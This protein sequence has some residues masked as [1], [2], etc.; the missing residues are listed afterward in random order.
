MSVVY[1]SSCD[2]SGKSIK[3]ENTTSG[4]NSYLTGHNVGIGATD[5]AYVL[6]IN[7]RSR[8]RGAGSDDG[9]G[10]WLTNHD[11]PTTNLSFIGRGTDSEDFVGIYTAGGW[12]LV[13]SDSSGYVGIG[14]TSPSCELDV[15]GTA[16]ASTA[17]KT[18]AIRPVTD[19]TTAVQVQS[20]GGSSVVLNVDTTNTR[21]GIG[22]TSPSDKLDVKGNIRITA[23][24]DSYPTAQII[25]ISHDN[26]SLNFD[27]YYDNA[28]RSSDPG[29]NFRIYKHEDKLRISH[30]SGIT[31]GDTIDRWDNEGSHVAFVVDTNGNVGIGI[32][33]LVNKLTAAGCVSIGSMYGG[34][35]AP[36]DGLIVQG[37]VGIGSTS[38]VSILEVKGV[39][40]DSN[41]GQLMV[42]GNNDHA[43][44]QVRA[45]DPT[46]NEVGIQLIGNETSNDPEWTVKIPAS[47]NNLQF[48][49][50]GG[51]VLTIVSDGAVG[52]GTTNPGE[53]LDV[54]GNIKIGASDYFYLG[55]SD[56]NGSWRFHIDGSD[57][58][59]ERRI[60]GSWVYKGGFTG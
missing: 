6:D 45:T 33:S 58:K 54:N 48:N 49:N 57:L 38:P 55:A 52:I 7:G 51:N 44:I 53:K 9:G 24:E 37:H 60:S 22:S 5:P 26:V 34:C 1:P 19:G 10:F 42:T 3:V 2:A 39:R 46:N 13:I 59:F 32:T 15:V 21:V 20:A 43:Y 28:W 47:S 40:G 25:N 29:S 4:E 35:T 36:T 14:S 27:S 16:Q 56:T 12:K 23:I 17:V 30:A 31:A 8:V 41:S 50:R 18:P 11:D